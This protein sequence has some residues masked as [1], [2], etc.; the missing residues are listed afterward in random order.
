MFAAIR[1]ASV[2]CVCVSG[3]GA[4]LSKNEQIGVPTAGG[5]DGRAI[6]TMENLRRRFCEERDSGIAQSRDSFVAAL[7]PSPLFVDYSVRL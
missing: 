4:V 3:S 6:V 1:G 5:P 7:L 2:G